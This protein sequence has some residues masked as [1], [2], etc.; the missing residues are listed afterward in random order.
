[1][2]K[3][4]SFLWAFSVLIF[5]SVTICLQLF[6]IKA[7]NGTHIVLLLSCVYGAIV[8]LIN[9]FSW[10]DIEAG[11][12]ESCNLAMLPMLILMLVGILISSWILAGTIPTLIYYGLKLIN[13][14]VFLVTVT[15]ICALGS[16]STGSTFTSA[17][18]FGVAFMGIGNGLGINSAMTAGAIVSGAVFGDKMTPLSGSSILAAGIMEV[19]I[20][21]HIKNLMKTA[22]P[23]F[24]ISLFIYL[25]LGF[26]NK[27]LDM[28]V[29]SL[30]YIFLG[31]EE[32]FKIS[33]I[34]LLPPIIVMILAIR[35]VPSLAVMVIASILG[36]GLSIFLQGASLRLVLNTLNLGYVG[37]TGIETLDRLLSGGGLQS[38]MNNV[39]L[40]F[41]G[42]SYG[43][44]LENT[45]VLQVILEKIE[46][47]LG[48]VRGLVVTHIISGLITNTFTASQY[49]AIILP[50]RMLLPAYEKLGL[51]KEMVARV[52]DEGAGVTSPLIPWGLCGAFFTATLGVPTLEY[53]FYTYTSLLIPLISVAYVVLN[54]FVLY[55]NKSKKIT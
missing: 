17:A 40:G 55:E 39:S 21:D 30:D 1:M 46:K 47:F 53:I 8:A 42:L 23:A 2:E 52:S 13:P 49:M 29:S 45:K 4:P 24:L 50:S 16:M 5:L 9:G 31:L 33:L 25:L 43:G 38:M 10:K 35:G 7:E 41:I 18:T 54:K 3:K 32:N 12:L 36:M 37:N 27:G 51:S 6:V 15:I 14:S 34:T 48:N 28:D 20:F 19:D 44:I 11:I 26:K 22:V